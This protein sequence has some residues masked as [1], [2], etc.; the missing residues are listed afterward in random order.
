MGN[1]LSW[2]N[3]TVDPGQ[4]S[5]NLTFSV[6]K[7]GGPFF[8]DQTFDIDLSKN[9]NTTISVKLDGSNGNDKF[10][11][12]DTFKGPALVKGGARQPNKVTPF[13]YDI[14]ATISFDI[15]KGEPPLY[16]KNMTIEAIKAPV[17]KP[18]P[19]APRMPVGS[20][21][22]SYQASSKNTDASLRAAQNLLTTIQHVGC[23][24]II[25]K[26]IYEI[27]NAPNQENFPTDPAVVEKQIVN[28]ITNI[29]MQVAKDTNNNSM[30]NELG[31]SMYQLFNI[32]LQNSTVNGKIDQSV[33]K[34]N[35][36]DMYSS[37][38]PSGMLG[39]YTPPPKIQ[40]VSSEPESKVA[41]AANAVKST[42]GAMS[43]STFGSM[44]GGFLIFLILLLIV[45]GVFYYL[46]SKGKVKIPG[47]PQRI[48][49]F[50]RQ[51]KAIRKM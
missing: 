2:Q 17:N 29:V 51:I 22:F 24:T 8:I 9:P 14:T 38:C 28:M 5:G 30:A 43:I 18:P 12:A 6:K 46:H 40:P 11:S 21:G 1:K 32:G 10:S 47:L 27:K 16:V 33:F 35:M 39:S 3:A 49:A 37:F 41:S 23:K 15:P 31:K 42:F 45:G 34:Q 4:A 20:L 25:P 7:I 44:G 19:P 26:I 13:N 36:I 50:G 48:A